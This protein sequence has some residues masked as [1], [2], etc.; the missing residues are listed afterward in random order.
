MFP[1]GHRART[2]AVSRRPLL[3]DLLL[4]LGRIAGVNTE[5]TGVIRT[6]ADLRPASTGAESKDGDAEG[7]VA[8]SA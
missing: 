1:V 6:D 4:L 5:H 2:D 8:A 7:D 3:V